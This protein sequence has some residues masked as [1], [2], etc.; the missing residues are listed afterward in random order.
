VETRNRGQDRYHM[1]NRPLLIVLSGLSGVGKDAILAKMKASGYPFAYIITVT[2][3]PKRAKEK[4]NVD[5]HFV[6]E[7]KFKEMIA[8]DELV[9]RANV[10]GSWY[11]V[12]RQSLEQALEAG[13]DTIIKVN[14]QGAATIKKIMPQ[15]VLIFLMPP[16][17][18]EL[19]TRL[20][21]R[22]TESSPDRELRIKTAEEESKQL[23]LFDYVVI[24]RQGELERAVEEITAIATAERC[25]LANQE[26]PPG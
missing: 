26:T 17:K 6:S 7:E 23:P 2:T 18:E 14:V 4:D 19:I 25:R 12:P 8:R 3:R 5:Y 11:G 20:K 22:R 1:P 16:S 10:Y 24:N 13:Q 9:E 21:Q 15:A